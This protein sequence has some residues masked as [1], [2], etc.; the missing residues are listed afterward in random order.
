[1]ILLIKLIVVGSW[2]V[3]CD[4]TGGTWGSSAQH[5]SEVD[6]HSTVRH[7]QK[8]NTGR[9]ALFG[10]TKPLFRY[11][12]LVTHQY[13][14]LFYFLFLRELLSGLER[15]TLR[16]SFCVYFHLCCCFLSLNQAAELETFARKENFLIQRSKSTSHASSANRTCRSAIRVVQPRS[17]VRIWKLM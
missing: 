2:R 5:T 7:K 3:C 8:W 11:L 13:Q 14:S 6:Q 15:W 9:I 12:T 17:M 4:V 10:R 16:C 1:M